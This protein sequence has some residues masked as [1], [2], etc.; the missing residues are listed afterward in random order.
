MI[1][2]LVTAATFGIRVLSADY[3]ADQFVLA[4]ADTEQIAALSTDAEKDFSYMRDRAFGIK[5]ARP[6]V[7]AV[8]AN[9]AD[10]VLR[11]WGGDEKRLARTGVKVLTLSY[12][13]DFEGVRQNIAEASDALGQTQRGNALIT[14]MNDRLLKLEKDQHASPSA[15]YITP[16]GVT[17]GKHTMIDAIFSV[18]GIQNA[19]ADAGYS[20]W[21]A[22]SVENLVNKPP[23][24]IVTGFFAANS[25]RI[26]NWSAT[27]HPAFQRA[28]T[29][30]PAV[31]L[32][33]DTVSCPAW[34]SVDAAEQIRTEV[35]RIWGSVSQ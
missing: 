19:I 8:I 35:N 17:A 13:A 29:K 22:Y 15:I 30:A 28:F 7:E 5:Q 21:P 18:A 31:N 11:F 9:N 32:E 1:A 25:E 23:Q 10:L 14:S 34:Y 12:A 27:Q 4:L 6:G 20:Y 24:L 2:T 3:C 26:N 16:G 33:A